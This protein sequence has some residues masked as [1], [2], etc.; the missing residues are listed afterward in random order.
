[1]RRQGSASA[2]SRP[3]DERQRGE[4]EDAR[5]RHLLVDGVEPQSRHRRAVDVADLVADVQQTGKGVA[6]QRVAEA[7]HEH[8]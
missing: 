3:R 4:D 7:R 6:R 2:A 8:G 5:G 1:M